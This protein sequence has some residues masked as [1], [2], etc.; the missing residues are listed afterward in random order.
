MA[1]EQVK[2]KIDHRSD[3]YAAGIVLWEMLVGRR[4][5]RGENEAHVIELI[6]HGTVPRA[7]DLDRVCGHSAAGRSAEPNEYYTTPRKPGAKPAR[8]P[9]R[10][11]ER[12]SQGRPT[13]RLARV[14]ARG[15]REGRQGR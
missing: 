3:I 9:V 1:P 14:L 4:L 12:R 5:F 10:A 6:C 11:L 15:R 7:A 2:G 8:R 13:K